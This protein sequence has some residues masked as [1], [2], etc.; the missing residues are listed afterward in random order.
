MDV[1]YIDPFISSVSNMFSSM[2]FSATH[3][4]DIVNET[5][6]LNIGDINACVE[7]SGSLSGTVVLTFPS[8][9]AVQLVNSLLAMELTD[10]DE[11]VIDGISEM[12][13]IVAGAAKAQLPV[14]GGEPIKLGIPISFQNDSGKIPTKEEWTRISFDGELGSFNLWISLEIR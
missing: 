12:A 9:T 11:T 14:A 7:L 6:G 10:V 1:V 3:S 4:G 8:K 5:N 2:L 13:N